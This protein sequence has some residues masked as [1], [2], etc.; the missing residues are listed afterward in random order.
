MLHGGIH[1]PDRPDYLNVRNLDLLPVPQIRRMRRM[2]IAIDIGAFERVA[3]KLDESLARLNGEITAFVPQPLLDRFAE[4]GE[5]FNPA[6][7]DQVAS[8]L[9]ETLNLAA[10][11]SLKRTKSGTRLSTGK[12][13]LEMIKRYHPVIP[14][15]L[16]YRE[17]SK[18]K[19]T[20]VDAL[21]RQAVLH[22][23]G[24]CFCGRKHYAA[25]HRI[26]TSIL[27]TRTETGRLASKHPNLQNI[28]V[29]TAMGREIRALF[30]APPGTRLISCD[31]AQIEL[32]LLAHC[33]NEEKMLAIF[34]AG[35]DIHL[36]TAMRAFNISDPAKVDKLLHRA[37]CKNLNFGVVFGLQPPG[38]YD[39]MAVTYA[40]AGQGM[41]D[42]LTL[43]WCTEFISRWFELYPGAWPFLSSTHTRARSQGV[44]WD[45]FGRV[46]RV[47]EVYSCHDRVVEAGLRQAGNMPIQ[48]AAAGFMKIGMALVEA[49]LE[50]MRSA[51]IN[52]EAL[53]S[54]HDEL[55]VEV[56]EDEAESTAAAVSKWMCQASDDEQG[57]CALRLPLEAE[58]KVMTEWRK[59]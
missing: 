19:T 30:V 31:Y 55:L 37:P 14:K 3:V 59:E 6:S 4:S 51:K 17:Y 45:M 10:G 38:L 52:V 28:P 54:I 53:M 27:T 2:G 1:L 9:F 48:S 7:P 42:W 44:V 47:P 8:L 58:A 12:K 16:E 35:G 43:S 29:R 26:H 11:T 46:R 57:V 49:C 41:P 33:A 23:K 40:T 50:R 32:R 20:Y 24:W 56:E 21:P 5:E 36:D 25:H 18:L 22:H 34:K 13:Q 39:L 15:L